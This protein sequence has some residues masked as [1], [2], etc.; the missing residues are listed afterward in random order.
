MNALPTTFA[1]LQAQMAAGLYSPTPI[2]PPPPHPAIAPQPL[3]AIP[4]PVATPMY[5]GQLTE[6]RVREMIAQAFAQRMD[7]V[8]QRLQPFD[9]LFAKALPDADYKAFQTYVAAGSPGFEA[10][11]KSDKFYPLVQLLWET[12]KENA[13]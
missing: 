5:A 10:M 13:K 4:A 7:A 12:I 3:P 1:E 11:M 8:N 2:T 9:A 6:D